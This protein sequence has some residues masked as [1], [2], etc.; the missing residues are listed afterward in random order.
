MRIGGMY[1]ADVRLGSLIALLVCPSLLLA[2]PLAPSGPAD[3]DLK[4]NKSC[5]GHPKAK[6][7]LAALPTRIPEM[8]VRW[9]RAGARRSLVGN[10][11]ATVGRV[12]LID[13]QGLLITLSV[14]LH[15]GQPAPEPRFVPWLPDDG[16]AVP[17]QGRQGPP[18][19]ELIW[20]PDDA[21][22][23]HV[24]LAGSPSTSHDTLEG[25]TSF[26]AQDGVLAAIAALVD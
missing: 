24:V 20:V 13:H 4:L 26:I 9:P 10:G 2:A 5:S 11:C 14:V 15:P 12:T 1:A 6:A 3:P 8:V 19:N 23:Y 17:A 7:V 18:R 16:E 22:G 21:R 25:D